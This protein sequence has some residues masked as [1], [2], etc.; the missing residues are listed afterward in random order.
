MA[1]PP[2]S[3]VAPH[4]SSIKIP[5]APSEVIG[6]VLFSLETRKNAPN[7]EKM[8]LCLLLHR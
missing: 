7:F 5:L 6:D 1:P 8:G 2:P 3:F 4:T